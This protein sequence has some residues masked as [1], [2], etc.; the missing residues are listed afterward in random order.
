[1]RLNT[2]FNQRIIKKRD[3]I[4][5]RAH[6]VDKTQ[7]LAKFD[8]VK[9]KEIKR[10]MAFL[11]SRKSEAKTAAARANGKKGGRPRKAK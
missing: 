2:R 8:G 6:G 7:R 9:Q 4:R 5:G 11:G 3:E 10:L 1:M